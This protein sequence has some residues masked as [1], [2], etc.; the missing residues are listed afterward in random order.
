MRECELRVA[1]WHVATPYV[2]YWYIREQVNK[3]CDSSSITTL[4]PQGHVSY[5][6]RYTRKK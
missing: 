6:R 2:L 4:Q 1:I 3:A 5:E